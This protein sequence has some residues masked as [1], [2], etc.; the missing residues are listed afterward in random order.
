[1]EGNNTSR[2]AKALPPYTELVQS[3]NDLK[4]R[5]GTLE[6]RWKTTITRIR[7][8]HNDH[9]L[10]L[11]EKYTLIVQLFTKTDDDTPLIFSILGEMEL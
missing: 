9:A 1:M 2:R 4:T 5:Y 10:S 7:S 11:E 8:I 3:H 6:N